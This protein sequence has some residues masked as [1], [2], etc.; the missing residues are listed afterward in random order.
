[1]FFLLNHTHSK[2][3]IFS[4]YIVYISTSLN[5]KI[6]VFVLFLLIKNFNFLIQNEYKEHQRITCTL[7]YKCLAQSEAHFR[8]LVTGIVHSSKQV[9]SC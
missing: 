8:N 1:M 6:H 5:K 3:M 9:F 2:S 4:F 7:V